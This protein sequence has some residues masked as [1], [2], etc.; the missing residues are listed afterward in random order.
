MKSKSKTRW[1]LVALLALF[2]TGCATTGDEET[3]VEDREG[4]TT[5]ELEA[6]DRERAAEARGLEGQR[7]LEGA[8]LDEMLEDPDSP[9]SRRIVYFAF[10]SSDIREE[11][12]DILESH[13][14]FLTDHPDQRIMVQG[15]TDERGSPAYNLALGERRAATVKRVLVINGASDEQIQVTSYGEEKPAEL[16][17][18][19]EAWSR[20]RRAELV[21]R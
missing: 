17:G 1:L 11:D 4:L 21:Y 5:E 3:R 12:M 16:G 9:I 18:D 2:L 8:E 14:A 15:H 19:E 10:D 20:N 13:A 6:I 7:M